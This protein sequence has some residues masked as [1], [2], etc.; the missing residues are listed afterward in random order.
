M[1][2]GYGRGVEHLKSLTLYTLRDH[3]V[4]VAAQRMRRGCVKDA[5]RM[6]KGR[7]S[8]IVWRL[9]GDCGEIAWRFQG[10]FR[11]ISVRLWADCMS[12]WRAA[13]GVE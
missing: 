12:R 7:G 10:D 2:I 6:R 3:V 9:Q 11:E 1:R 8:E 5:Q 13:V 4:T